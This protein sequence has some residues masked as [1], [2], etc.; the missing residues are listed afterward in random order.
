MTHVLAV[1]LLLGDPLL[2]PMLRPLGMQWRYDF[3]R[4]GLKSLT[5]DHLQF[6]F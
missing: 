1:M 5:V 6:G 2:H 4:I 3:S